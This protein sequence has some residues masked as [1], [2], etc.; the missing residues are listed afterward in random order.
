MSASINL[1]PLWDAILDVYKQFATI[2]ER[3][4]LTYCA[5][6][7]TALG[8]I[9]HNGFIPWDDDL[10]VQMPRADYMKFIQIAPNELPKGYAWLDKNNCPAYEQ[11]FGKVIVTD[12][13][14]VDSI[15]EASGLKLGQGIFIDVFP[16]DGYPDG[17]LGRFWRNCENGIME[18]FAAITKLIRECGLVR[19]KEANRVWTHRVMS[20][21]YDNRG[22]RYPFGSTSMCVSVG[23]SRKFDDKPYLYSYFG[24]PRKVKFDSDEMY[25][26][27]NADGYLRQMFGDYMKLPPIA[28]RHP[29]HGLGEIM[30]WRLGPI[31]G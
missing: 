20:D 30:P 28:N 26:Q 8:A 16:V 22:K 10:D 29:G 4:D 3:H 14:K 31:C 7:G 13:I 5:D 27:E 2:C 6:T 15:A 18:M 9:R 23:L 21:F 17:R 25:V 19:N 11:A 1:R 12:R 24:K